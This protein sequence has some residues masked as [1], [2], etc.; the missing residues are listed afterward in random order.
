MPV[1]VGVLTEED[2]Q[3]L[4]LPSVVTTNKKNTRL[5]WKT[6]AKLVSCCNIARLELNFGKKDSIW[7]KELAMKY[8]MTWTRTR[9]M[10]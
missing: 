8:T 4:V 7:S 10:F 2:N 9:R 1:R 3:E 5:T 6:S